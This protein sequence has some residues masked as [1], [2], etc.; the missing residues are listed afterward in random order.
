MV[1]TVTS[2]TFSQTYRD[3]FSDSDNY[4]R[5]LFNSGRAL[6]ARELTQL[7]TI[8]QKEA[9][10]HARFIFKEG[11]AV[12]SG[13][14]QINTRFE[15]AKLNTTTYALPDSYSSLIGE[16]FTGLTSTIK[17]RVIAIEPATGGDPATI[18]IEY[19][20]NNSTSATSVPVRLTP[21]EVLTGAVS[22]TNLQVQT[23]NTTAN[24]AVGRG[25]RLSVNES[26]MFTNGH[27]VF[28]PKQSIILSKYSETPTVV[29]GFTVIET[30]VTASD[31]SALYD[32]S[33]ATPNLTAPGADR[34]KITLALA[35]QPNVDAN[36]TFIPSFDI[37]NG[38]IAAA[39]VA[40]ENSLSVI[41][42]IMATRTF[43]ES[44]SYTVKPYIIKTKNADSDQNLAITIGAGIGYIEGYRHETFG[45][46]KIIIEKPR[47]T[48][49]INNDV[50]AAEY[51]N[52]I[53]SDS[54]HGIPQINTFAPVNL[55]DQGTYGGSTIGTARIRA[56]EPVGSGYRTYLF[57]VAMTGA[58]NFSA[59]KSIG[60]STADFI[61]LTLENSVG[62]IKDTA[63][64][65]LFFP[66]SGI[67]P[68]A[69]S[70][71][72]LT[73]QR[74]FAGTTTVSGTIQFT[75]AASGE[76]FSNSSNW[77]VVRTD[78]GA[79]GVVAISA[80]GNG[81]A[82]V[83]LSGLP[84]STAVALAAYVNKGLATVKTKTLTNATATITPEVDN[85]VELTKADIYRI[86][87]VRDGSASGNIITSSYILDT[88]QRDN[89]YAEGKLILRTGYSAPSGD[90]YIDYD[91][92]VHGASGDFF[93]VNSYTGQVEY[94]N[95]PA[96]R[97]R[98]GQ[99]IY[100]R[101]VLDFRSRKA[102]TVDDFTSTGAVRL[103][104][105]ANTDLITSDVS[106]YHGQAYRIGL[107]KDGIFGAI[108]GERSTFPVYPTL[109]SGMMELYRLAINPYC[110]S[111]N[112]VT[113]EYVDNRRYTM[114][115]IGDL[116][117]RMNKIEE[118]TTLNMLEL[119][120]ATLEVLDDAGNNRLKVGLTADNF[121]DHFQ[122]QRASIEYKASTDA[123][124][125]E[126]RPSFVSRSSELVYDSASSSGVSLIG[127]TVYPNYTEELYVS[128]TSVSDPVSVNAFNLGVAVGSIKMSPSSD[129]WY[130]DT[131]TPDKIIDG[132]IKL[133]PQNSSLWNDWGF[134]WSGLAASELKVGYSQSKGSTSGNTT[135]TVTNTIVSDEIVVTSMNDVILYETS[136]QYMRNRFVFIK[137]QGLRPNTRYFPFF[138]G[139]DVS[140]WVQAGSGKFNYFAALDTTSN[141]LDPGTKYANSTSYPA[142]LGG[143]TSEIFSDTNGT[144]EAI[145]FVPDRNDINFLTGT[146]QLVLID[147]S[148][149]NFDD[150]TSY[151]SAEFVSQGT[152]N[153]WQETLKHTRKYNIQGSV[154]VYTEPQQAASTNN[155][156]QDYDGSQ[157][158][159]WG[160]SYNSNTG[161][162]AVTTGN[163]SFHS[164]VQEAAAGNASQQA[165]ADAYDTH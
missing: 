120:T 86:N 110:L 149:L 73:T 96:Y 6:Q 105:P 126:L 54:C 102:D 57:D 63:N 159:E 127:D 90:V 78:T 50:V 35:L 129:I 162:Y 43:E 88:G 81:T 152:L 132:G 4:H 8:I 15:F 40:G 49:T 134:N 66:L 121:K 100:L 18:F 36:T 115:D 69:L 87:A 101:D 7:Q 70:D 83:T 34:F 116:E 12:H 142:A 138:D 139:K 80:G 74:R 9:E 19:T 46:S 44:G 45:T 75:L 123:F 153:H 32:N 22:G 137:A 146:R 154:S 156:D 51:G 5:I 98:N 59:V 48:E 93:A 82:S 76:T 55:R 103:E 62:V 111:E 38:A 92:F 58:N 91:Y 128:N 28:T 10:R 52:Y 26:V 151:A 95:I 21:G 106:Y 133:D 41:Q 163:Q 161:T 17:A 85:S 3:D 16:I 143:A 135:T 148:V 130:S 112:D 94:A 113:L 164:A 77:V 68:S 125:R 97:Q 136:I 71:I 33:N 108:P 27:F 122:S 79:L 13:G 117:T 141:Y 14:L 30:I 65:N 107:S 25:A 99:T 89:F 56:I 24:P 140:S 1:S 157:N 118:I 114:R 47:T 109:P 23:T 150:A 20:D 124:N 31:E 2:T 29:V 158:G 84:N 155:T 42:D 37:V 11:A 67:R 72:S 61:N 160:V 165:I 144:V 147:I 53:L 145:F 39:K 60:I 131:R 64:N 104:L 119:E